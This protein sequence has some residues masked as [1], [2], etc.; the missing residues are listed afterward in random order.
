MPSY[1]DA[2]STDDSTVTWLIL[3]RLAESPTTK[4]ALTFVAN[5]GGP[6]PPNTGSGTPE[7][8]AAAPSMIVE[9]RSVPTRD[10]PRNTSGMDSPLAAEYV[11]EAT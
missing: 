5:G 1:P 10:T 2:F 11:P 3:V 4:A 8:T 7:S 6:R 9:L